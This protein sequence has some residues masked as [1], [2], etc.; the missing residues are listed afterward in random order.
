MF[1]AR[2]SEGLFNLQRTQN[3][4]YMHRS[5]GTMRDALYKH[6]PHHSELYGCFVLLLL[7]AKFCFIYPHQLTLGFNSDNSNQ[8]QIT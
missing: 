7:A 5:V 1:I 4:L 3:F 6:I 2:D 8:I